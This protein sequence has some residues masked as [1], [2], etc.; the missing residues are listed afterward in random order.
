[1]KYIKK[2]LLFTFIISISFLTINNVS[3]RT[4]Q[5][6]RK[7]L[8]EMKAKKLENEKNA[9]EIQ[10]KVNAA[11]AKIKQI[12]ID[13][14]TTMQEAADKEDEIKELEIEIKEK[15]EQIKELVSFLQISDSENFYLKYVFGAENF[16]D[17]I[18]RVS[19]IEQLTKKSDELVDKM[20]NLIEENKER[21]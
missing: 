5:D 9:A 21:D 15:E 13:V 7:E 8:E 4:I 6:Y 20:N 1:M 3:A 14:S 12:Q 11:K 10:Q 17:L 16:T 18:Y 2:I 19:V